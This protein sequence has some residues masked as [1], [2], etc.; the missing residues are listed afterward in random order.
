MFK[1]LRSS[2]HQRPFEP[3]DGRRT[4][5]DILKERC[6]LGEIDHEEFEERRRRVND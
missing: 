6:A 3:R 2:G 1:W 5:L 4:A